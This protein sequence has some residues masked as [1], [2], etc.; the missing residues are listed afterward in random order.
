MILKKNS[1]FLAEGDIALHIT[2]DPRIDKYD[3][4]HRVPRGHPY[5]GFKIADLRG[6]GAITNDYVVWGMG[7]AGPRRLPLNKIFSAPLPLP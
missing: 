3:S 5:I 4:W 2:I 1:D 6:N 7:S